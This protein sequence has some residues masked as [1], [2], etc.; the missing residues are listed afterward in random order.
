MDKTNDSVLSG[1]NI[2]VEETGIESLMVQDFRVEFPFYKVG[3][4]EPNEVLFSKTFLQ[5]KP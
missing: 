5:Y 2:L 3:T 1:A 4:I